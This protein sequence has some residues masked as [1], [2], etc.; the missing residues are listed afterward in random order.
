MYLDV[1]ERGGVDIYV[2]SNFM[3]SQS[4]NIS[5]PK[6]F[7][8]LVVDVSVNQNTHVFVAGIYSPHAAMAVAI[9]AISECLT[10]FF[11]SE[12][13]ILGDLNLD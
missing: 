7:E 11:L 8:L 5:V 1:T 2:K 4:W 13:V 6:K 12:L 9:S 10:F 3:A